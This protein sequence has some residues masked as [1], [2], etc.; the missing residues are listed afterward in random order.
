MV[1][2]GLS[3]YI[4]VYLCIS[5]YIESL[6][7]CLVREAPI[8]HKSMSVVDRAHNAMAGFVLVDLF[9][10]LADLECTRRGLPRGSLFLAPE[11]ARNL[12]H[13]ALSVLQVCLSKSPEGC[14]WSRGHHRLTELSVEQFF[15][16]LRVQSSSAN[17]SSRAYWQASCRDMLR[18]KARHKKPIPIPSKQVE[19][20][21]S[22]DFWHE[23]E[24]ALRSAIKLA[25]W[26]EGVTGDSLSTMYSEWCDEDS[27]KVGAGK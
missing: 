20:L 16:R 7:G 27:F 10:M 23:S 1:Y 9:R 21:G 2:L 5:D 22:S 19:P 24:K 13:C 6:W 14:L 25:A 12:Q 11:T 15:G 26:C 3:W 8:S 17:L 18:N 4:M